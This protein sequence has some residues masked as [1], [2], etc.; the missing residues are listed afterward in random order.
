MQIKY[1]DSENSLYQVMKEARD[2]RAH[3]V[4]PAWVTENSP[5]HDVLVKVFDYPSP[6]GRPLGVHGLAGRAWTRPAPSADIDQ[7]WHKVWALCDAVNDNYETGTLL[8]HYRLTLLPAYTITRPL[9]PELVRASIQDMLEAHHR[10]SIDA[11]I[12]V[13]SSMSDKTPDGAH[14][15]LQ[16]HLEEITTPEIVFVH[17]VPDRK[18][19]A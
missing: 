18:V 9:K 8:P 19:R 6:D 7:N 17:H 15:L 10:F 4:V 11:P 14:E 1:P 16:Q 2:G 5:L 13:F 12:Y 3:C